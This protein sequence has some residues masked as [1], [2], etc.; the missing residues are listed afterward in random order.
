MRS[1]NTISGRLAILCALAVTFA[2]TVG[3]AAARRS[4]GLYHADRQ[5]PNQP[6]TRPGR[7]T[8]C[9]GQQPRRRSHGRVPIVIKDKLPPGLTAT[10]INGACELATLRCEYTNILSPYQEP[11]EFEITVKALEN[12]PAMVVDEVSVSGGGAA[13]TVTQDNVTV[14]STPAGFRGR[15]SSAGADQRRRFDRH[16][17]GF[18]P[19]RVDDH[20]GDERGD[21]RELDQTWLGCP[22]RS[23]QGFAVPICQPA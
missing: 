17:S 6:A 23:Y 10:A 3:A 14:S 22:A 19:I 5:Q 16:A 1:L 7:H 8:D 9:A 2:A 15:K 20:A 21:R 4:A 11:I 12:A 13:S 18:A